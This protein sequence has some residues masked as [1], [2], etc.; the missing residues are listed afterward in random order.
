MTFLAGEYVRQS[1]AMIAAMR[2][3]PLIGVS[4]L[5]FGAAGALLVAENRIAGFAF[6]AVVG[7]TIV[8]AAKA[9][10]RDRDYESDGADQLWDKD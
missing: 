3:A 8:I 1:R 6:G 10:P 7:L 2:A 4:M 5:L 9:L